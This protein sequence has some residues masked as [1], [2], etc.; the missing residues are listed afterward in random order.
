MVGGRRGA[1]RPVAGR[2]GRRRPAAGL[3]R[4]P[5]PEPPPRPR[6]ALAAV[7][8]GGLLHDRVQRPR[9]QRRRRAGAAPDRS[10]AA[11]LP[12]RRLLRR[13]GRAGPRLHPDHRR[14]ALGRRVPAGPDLRRPAQGLRA[15]GAERHPADLDDRLAPAPRDGHGVR[16]GPG[17]RRHRLPGRRG[18]GVQLRRRLGQPL[19]RGGRAE[20]RRLGRPP[21]A[22]D[23][24]AVRL[25]GQR[26][27]HQHPVPAR[28]GGPDAVR[29]ARPG[30]HRRRRRRSRAAAR[31]RGRGGRSGTRRTPSRRAAPAHGPVHGPRRLRRRAGVPVPVGDPRRLRPRPAAGH[32]G[33]CWPGAASS[34]RPRAWPATSRPASWSW[35]RPRRCSGGSS[36]CPTRRR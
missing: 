24:G 25:R 2:R 32:G 34:P 8:T 30:L 4:R 22:R 20:R 36:G 1:R 16:A 11:A 26:H 18:G 31:R 17:R 13:P 5:D 15:P 33:G 29:A 27:R 6:A 9:E 19:H 12:V 7:E 23:A 35:T 28:L 3:L 10:G 21:G 14:A